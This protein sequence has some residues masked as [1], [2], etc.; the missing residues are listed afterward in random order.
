VAN[1]DRPN[2]EQQQAVWL[3]VADAGKRAGLSMATIL[4][5]ARRGDLMGY[6]VGFGKKLWRFRPQDIDAWIMAGSTPEPA[7]LSRRTP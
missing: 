6:K 1:V 7:V 4:R 3:D 5:A 2:A